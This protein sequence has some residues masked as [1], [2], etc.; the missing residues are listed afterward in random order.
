MIEVGSD[1]DQLSEWCLLQHSNRIKSSLSVGHYTHTY[2]LLMYFEWIDNINA[3]IGPFVWFRFIS[4][5]LYRPI[6]CLVKLKKLKKKTRIVFIYEIYL[7]DFRRGGAVVCTQGFG[8]NS[9]IE[10]RSWQLCWGLISAS[11]LSCASKLLSIACMGGDCPSVTLKLYCQLCLVNGSFI[12][13]IVFTW[14]GRPRLQ[15]IQYDHRAL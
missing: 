5:A 4:Y 7:R 1:T 2:L 3:W 6:A 10:V 15:T 12:F 11:C 14:W 13:D 8:L 9:Y